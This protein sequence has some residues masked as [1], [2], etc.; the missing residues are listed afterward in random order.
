MRVSIVRKNVD[1]RKSCARNCYGLK[2]RTLKCR[3][4]KCRHENVAR[5]N[6][7]SSVYCS[8]LRFYIRYIAVFIP[9]TKDAGEN[10]GEGVRK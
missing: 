10:R 2:C 7:L 6:V 9:F 3:A 5:A 1:P 4:P 8:N